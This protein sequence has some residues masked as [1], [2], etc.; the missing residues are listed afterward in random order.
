MCTWAW[1]NPHPS[2]LYETLE[3]M[4]ERELNERNR[5]IGVREKG[6][7]SAGTVMDGWPRSYE[8]L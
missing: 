1:K 6:L 4:S 5:R 7:E 8:A 2:N 3:D